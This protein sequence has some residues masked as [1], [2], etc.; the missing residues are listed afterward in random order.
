MNKLVLISLC[1]AALVCASLAAFDGLVVSDKG[2]LIASDLSKTFFAP[3][4]ALAI[5]VDSIVAAEEAAGDHAGDLAITASLTF[6]IDG[7]K[8]VPSNEAICAAFIESLVNNKVGEAASF[9][10]CSVSSSDMRRKVCS[11]SMLTASVYL[12]DSAAV[13]VQ[14]GFA[15]VLAAILALVF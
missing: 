9:H 2:A 15:V 11:C 3:A 8:P 13:A 12:T 6:P 7:D 10:D 4:D 5:T 1:L 14:L